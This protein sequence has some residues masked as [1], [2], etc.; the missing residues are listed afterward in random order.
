M[1]LFVFKKKTDYRRFH[2]KNSFLCLKKKRKTHIQNKFIDI[3]SFFILFF[4]IYIEISHY[5]EI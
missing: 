1:L 2:N 3:L 4:V 5:V